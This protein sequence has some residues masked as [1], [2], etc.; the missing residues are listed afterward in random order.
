VVGRAD[1]EKLPV[2]Q[3]PEL[4]EQPKLLGISGTAGNY[5]N[6]RES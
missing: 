1:A 5:R 2:S 4:S 6:S 3:N